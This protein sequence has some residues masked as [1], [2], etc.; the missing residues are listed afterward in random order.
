MKKAKFY[1]NFY[2]TYRFV[3]VPRLLKSDLMWKDK[4]DTPRCER[5]PYIEIEWMWFGFYGCW[6]SDAY[7]EQWLWVY[8]Y[9][10]GDIEKAKKEWDWIDGDTKISTWKDEYVK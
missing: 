10:G 1:F 2:K 3:W 9:H 5:E 8:K 4:F 7:W 6:G